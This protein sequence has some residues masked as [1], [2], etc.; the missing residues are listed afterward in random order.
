MLAIC[1]KVCTTVFN[2]L[3][4]LIGRDAK[5]Y[6]KYNAI[7]SEVDQCASQD[8][9]CGSSAISEGKKVLFQELVSKQQE[10]AVAD[11]VV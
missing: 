2:L 4:I 3:T 6:A 5:S 9:I 1:F 8:L 7:D 11:E 10:Q